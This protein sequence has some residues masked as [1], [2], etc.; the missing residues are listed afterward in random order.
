MTI[1]DLSFKKAISALTKLV[2]LNESGIDD[3]K[4]KL[5]L[6]WITAKTEFLQK[7]ER[8]IQIPDAK[9][10][11]TISIQTYT[12]LKPHL[13]AIINAAY[14][15]CDNQYVRNASPVSISDSTTLFKAL[16]LTKKSI[17]WVDFGFNIG[18]EFGGRHPAVI[19]RNLGELL[20]VAPI[21]TNTNGVQESNT[22][23]T[24]SP[25]DVYRLPSLRH[26]FTNI[27]RL[28]PVSLIRVDFDSPI[29]SMR[30]QK[31]NEIIEK[32]KLFF[33]K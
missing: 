16:Y 22:I 12:Y 4:L 3:F 29:G 1:N 17:V 30:T 8:P 33:E 13:Q 2:E 10:P 20:L 15:L 6:D 27:T 24:F 28:T 11:N 7:E 18:K 14:N 31:F 21:S 25:Q 5:Y 9:L 32:I 23:I 26:R 19:L